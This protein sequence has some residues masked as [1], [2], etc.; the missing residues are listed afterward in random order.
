MIH[1]E[2]LKTVVEDEQDKDNKETTLGDTEQGQKNL[3][4]SYHH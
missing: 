3:Y 2:T 1:K 4:L